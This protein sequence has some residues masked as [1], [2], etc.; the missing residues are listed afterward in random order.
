MIFPTKLEI[1]L[2]LTS[3]ILNQIV[4]I[5]VR[6]NGRQT[7]IDKLNEKDLLEILRKV[8]EAARMDL[9]SLFYD[10]PTK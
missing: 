8:F 4:Q 6:V 5:K 9:R 10:I 3:L 1:S 7:M 2:L